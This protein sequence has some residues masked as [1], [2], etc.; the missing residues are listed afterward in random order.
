[1]GLETAP[2]DVTAILEEDDMSDG[3]AVGHCRAVV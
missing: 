3:C 1:M 2:R